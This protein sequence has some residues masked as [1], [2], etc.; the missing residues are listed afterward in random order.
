MFVYLCN[1]S[2]FVDLSFCRYFMDD[3]PSS[4]PLKCLSHYDQGIISP[5]ADFIH[6][7]A[8]SPWIFSK[9]M[10]SKIYI[11]HEIFFFYIFFKQV[12]KPLKLEGLER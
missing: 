7:Y 1:L 3:Y 5:A 9:K 8:P 4:G 2:L 12:D 10:L 6:L 11:K